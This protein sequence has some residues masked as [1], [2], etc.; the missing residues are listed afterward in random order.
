MKVLEEMIKQTVQNFYYFL[1]AKSQVIHPGKEHKAI[2]WKNKAHTGKTEWKT[3]DPEKG[4]RVIRD[5]EL[6]MRSQLNTVC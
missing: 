1:I 2:P 4:T 3:N 6:N 5:K